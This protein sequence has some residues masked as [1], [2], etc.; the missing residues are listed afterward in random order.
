[1]LQNLKRVIRKFPS[2]IKKC[3]LLKSFDKFLENKILS[4]WN[5]EIVVSGVGRWEWASRE[6]A[7]VRRCLCVCVCVRAQEFRGIGRWKNN[8]L[9]LSWWINKVVGNCV[10]EHKECNYSSKDICVVSVAGYPS[11][12]WRFC[13]YG[14][15]TAS[16]H[17]APISRLMIHL[18]LS[19]YWYVVLRT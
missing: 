3:K 5:E 11:S 4:G 9:S 15:V 1:M 12:C 7:Y 19:V 10:L 17:V 16:L 8:G 2:Q 18:W 13:F 14:C 6:Y